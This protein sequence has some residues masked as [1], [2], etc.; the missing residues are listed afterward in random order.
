MADDG[1]DANRLLAE[2]QAYGRAKIA[3]NAVQTCYRRLW[4]DESQSASGR[5]RLRFLLER[6]EDQGSLECP[7]AP[8]LWR[9]GRPP[10]PDHVR[11]RGMRADSTAVKQRDQESWL[12]EMAFAA[13]LRNVQQIGAARAIN[14]F[15]KQ[16][17]DLNPPI[18]L[19]ERSL[20]IFGDEKRLDTLADARGYLLN[21]GVHL[22]DL[23]CFRVPQP[24]PFEA[25]PQGSAGRPLLVVENHHSY[26]SV[27]EWNARSRRYA[28][29][30][31]GSGNAWS[32]ASA[33]GEAGSGSYLD[34]IVRE[35]GA[36]EIRYFGDL[37]PPGVKIPYDINA[38]REAAALSPVLPDVS[39][40]TALLKQGIRRP[41]KSDRSR[42]RHRRAVREWLGSEL[43]GQ[44][45]ALFDEGQCLPQEGLTY[46]DLMNEM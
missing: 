20:Q 11:L 42:S 31:Y 5:Q 6:L 14:A 26:W 10:L 8:H 9:P 15:L 23:G 46:A 7:K 36:V 13:S 35:V 29:V 22:T 16:R 25:G 32:R 2:L 19:R 1:Q 24:I 30:A 28:A 18:P 44:V 39:L 12:P 3:L 4:P 34:F 38:N 17:P 33:A 41:L 27:K 40:Y 43:A 21:G 37:D 45:E